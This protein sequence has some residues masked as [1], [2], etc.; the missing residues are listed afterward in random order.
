[1]TLSLLSFFILCTLV[2]ILKVNYER[3]V[4]FK[5]SVFL[6][7]YL[8]VL[9]NLLILICLGLYTLEAGALSFIFIM[10]SVLFIPASLVYSYLIIIA[11]EQQ[12][13]HI[14]KTRIVEDYDIHLF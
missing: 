5:N 10:M 3:K 6:K 2:S 12:I 9:S 11:S 7:V 8:L 13:H 14:V 4:I 1:M